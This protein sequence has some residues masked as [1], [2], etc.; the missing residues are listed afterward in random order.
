MGW[1]K[2]LYT[3][4]SWFR[5]II[6]AAEGGLLLAFVDFTAKGFDFS[7][8]GW[9]SLLVALGGGMVVAVRNYLV[10]RPGSPAGPTKE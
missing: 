8:E 3:T 2:D 4:N 9:K 7:R 10:N 5:G 1:L 6:Q